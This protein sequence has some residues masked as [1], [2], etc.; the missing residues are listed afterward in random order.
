MGVVRDVGGGRGE[1]RERA[2]GVGILIT[3]YYFEETPVE[4]V[5][6]CL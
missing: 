5:M 2:E 6:V 4:N 1:G 3:W